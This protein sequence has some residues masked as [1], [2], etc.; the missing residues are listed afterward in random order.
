M[1][2]CI[3]GSVQ[4]EKCIVRK[5]SIWGN[6]FRGNGPLEKFLQPFHIAL[7]KTFDN[8]SLEKITCQK[9]GYAKL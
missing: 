6:A 1:L 3:V 2:F 7:G 4:S 8:S 9:I 5:M